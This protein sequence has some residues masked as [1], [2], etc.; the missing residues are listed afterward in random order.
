[1]EQQDELEKKLGN[2]LLKNNFIL[3][4]VEAGT[5]V[6]TQDGRVV[7]SSHSFGKD[8]VESLA[9]RTQFV[10]MDEIAR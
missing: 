1:M 3:M 7:L 10:A 5:R 8:A 2:W 9:K 4:T 6:C